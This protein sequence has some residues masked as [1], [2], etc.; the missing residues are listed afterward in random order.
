MNECADVTYQSTGRCSYLQQI[1]FKVLLKPIE[2]EVSQWNRE[3]ACCL[4]I[5]IVSD[6]L[7]DKTCSLRD[8]G[9]NEE[10]FTIG[11]T[12]GVSQ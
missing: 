5:Q 10:S 4:H 7:Y 2:E 3:G 11:M 12:A 9:V 1:L 6:L 8:S